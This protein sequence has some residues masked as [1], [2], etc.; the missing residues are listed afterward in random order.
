M[1]TKVIFRNWKGNI[2][3]LFPEIPA[4]RYNPLLCDSYMRVGQHAPAL[5][6][7]II[8]QSRPA[9]WEEYN[10]LRVELETVYKYDLEIRKRLSRKTFKALLK[11]IN[12]GS[13]ASV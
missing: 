10:S 9:T 5:Y 2:I 11:N 8:E 3:A 1:K 7:C 13:N 12:G 4:T 6:E